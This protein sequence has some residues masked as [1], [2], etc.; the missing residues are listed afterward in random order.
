MTFVYKIFTAEILNLIKQVTMI[1]ERK[2][3]AKRLAVKV[4][5]QMRA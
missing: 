2:A 1:V 4:S 5:V 3:E